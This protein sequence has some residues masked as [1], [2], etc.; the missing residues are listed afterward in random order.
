[1]NWNNILTNLVI[2]MGGT[3]GM[4]LIILRFCKKR[5]ETYI[6]NAINYS[7]DK[8]LE[9]YKQKLNKQFSS[10]KSFADK[11]NECI[12]II[13]KELNAAG[14]YIKET[15]EC[16]NRCL[17]E[18]LT[19]DFVFK[20]QGGARSVEGLFSVSQELGQTK[21]MCQIY[22]PKHIDDDIEA[23]LSLINNYTGGINRELEN[24]QID[25]QLCQGLLDDGQTI[26]GKVD[27]LSSLIREECLRKSGEL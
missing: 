11:H 9:E 18:Q 23:A 4:A 26:R 16:I 6:D 27:S 20:Q 8:K 13:I 22:L 15:Q 10:Y 2:S 24:L 17:S 7:F 3:L 5:V 19:L 25:R 21:V 1:M 14:K 12:D